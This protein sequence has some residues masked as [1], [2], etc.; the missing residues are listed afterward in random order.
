MLNRP[1]EWIARVRVAKGVAMDPTIERQNKRK[2][3][4]WPSEP[5]RAVQDRAK[6]QNSIDRNMISKMI[7]IGASARIE[8]QSGR[9]K[10]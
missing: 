8:L 3:V 9:D 5:F 10:I 1:L 4:R 7:T 6:D 2:M